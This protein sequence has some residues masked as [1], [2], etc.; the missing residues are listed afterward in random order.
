M[1]MTNVPENI[2]FP[3]HR[4]PDYTLSDARVA[5]LE[6]FNTQVSLGAYPMDSL[7]KDFLAHFK[8]MGLCDAIRNSLSG[9]VKSRL[10]SC[11]ALCHIASIGKGRDFLATQG[12]LEYADRDALTLLNEIPLSERKAMLGSARLGERYQIVIKFEKIDLNIPLGSLCF[13]NGQG[14]LTVEETRTLLLDRGSRECSLLQQFAR[15]MTQTR[16]PGFDAQI[17]HAWMSAIERCVD[18]GDMANFSRERLDMLSLGTALR[19][20]AT[21][22]AGYMPRNDGRLANMLNQTRAAFQRAGNPKECALAYADIGTYLLHSGEINRAREAYRYAGEAFDE[23]MCAL[24]AVKRVADAKGCRDLALQA[25]GN[26]RDDEAAA[27]VLDRFNSVA[28]RQSLE[29]G[30]GDAPLT[31]REVEGH[32]AD[33]RPALSPFHLSLPG[34]IASQLA[35]AE[36]ASRSAALRKRL[37]IDSPASETPKGPSTPI[38]VPG[39]RR[40]SPQ[41][42]VN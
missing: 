27:S 3:L 38:T 4:Y 29:I 5:R 36:S 32:R 22:E 12:M 18:G 23:A 11:A 42:D 35:S 24:L 39:S 16:T 26:A 14:A 21:K 6:D 2:N 31:P 17:G 33:W 10:L 1:P 30:G 28:G 8:Y 40:G 37:S 20:L 41:G 19:A 9:G 7:F 13:G 34:A 15:E 25:Y